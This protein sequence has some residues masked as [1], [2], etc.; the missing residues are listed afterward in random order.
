MSL[1]S[2]DPSLLR[3]L[4]YGAD[5]WSWI[6]VGSTVYTQ[7]LATNIGAPLRELARACWAGTRHSELLYGSVT[8]DLFGVTTDAY[9]RS[10]G[11]GYAAPLLDDLLPGILRASW[12]S[13]QGTLQRSS[14]RVC[15]A[16]A[17]ST[18]EAL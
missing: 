15:G 11:C 12:S 9:L 13:L 18:G 5:Q 1:Q 7:A 17:Y 14:V 8:T 2:A 6:A 16:V 3:E 4:D 10:V